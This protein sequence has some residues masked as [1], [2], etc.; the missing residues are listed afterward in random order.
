VTPVMSMPLG[1]A[2]EDFDQ[3]LMAGAGNPGADI[4]SHGDRCG[5]VVRTVT[6]YRYSTH[7]MRSLN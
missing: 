4:A 5:G 3:L 1:G 6:I 7:G 2:V